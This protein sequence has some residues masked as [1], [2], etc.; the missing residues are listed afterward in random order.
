MSQDQSQNAMI[1]DPREYWASSTKAGYFYRDPV[2][3]AIGPDGTFVPPQT[4]PTPAGL[5]A[6][7]LGQGTSPASTNPSDIPVQSA[8]TS[9]DQYVP[10][11]YAGPVGPPPHLRAGWA[12]GGFQNQFR[13]NYHH[14]GYDRGPPSRGDASYAPTFDSRSQA[15]GA[16]GGYFRGQRSSRQY[17]PVPAQVRVGTAPVTPA[18]PFVATPPPDIT[19]AK[20]DGNGHPVFPFAHPHDAPIEDVVGVVPGA[21]ERANA[22]HRTETARIEEW[23]RRLTRGDELP[24]TPRAIDP[25]LVGV[26]MG[27]TIRTHAQAANLLRW[28]DS[29]CPQSWAM[30]QFVEQSYGL[31][32]LAYRPVGVGLI[33]SSQAGSRNR[34]MM[35]TTGAPPQSK[36]AARR[37]AAAARTVNNASPSTPG[38]SVI[39][40][41]LD[42]R[43]QVDEVI[44]DTD[45]SYVEPARVAV[46]QDVEMGAIS[47]CLGRS[48]AGDDTGA[49]NSR[50]SVEE[51]RDHWALLPTSG[52][53]K[54]MR[55]EKGVYPEAE[56][57]TPLAIDA[58]V[59]LTMLVFGPEDKLSLAEFTHQ[60]L[61]MFSCAGMFDEFCRVGGYHS[62]S[63]G[64]EHYNF[65]TTGL[66][67]S[68]L[69][70]WWC[71]HGIAPSSP[72]VFA[73]ESFARSHRNRVEGGS[74]PENDLFVNY[75]N[76]RTCVRTLS[77]SEIVV[78][79][80]LVHGPLCPSLH[81]GYPR[82]PKEL[83]QEDDLM[84]GNT[85]KEEKLDWSAE[86]QVPVFKF[87]AATT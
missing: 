9:R 85:P 50:T 27:T 82:H 28:S 40:A 15:R 3:G 14:G 55:T 42:A 20:R 37:A 23:G 39:V 24:R 63:R 1:P 41:T 84:G 48:P 47:A 46:E 33:L 64:P 6:A 66:D 11:G 29:G 16:R 58:C 32:P 22:W 21:D 12:R 17:N 38:P 35:A 10:R 54:A 34:Y 53:P 71:T 67:W 79:E 78:W 49:L 52:W 73:F 7:Y 77:S 80:R 75:P 70:S 2:I 69:A 8:P 60:T 44:V 68:L 72:S 36:K 25:A 65:I 4:A 5:L 19:V 86:E 83:G 13:G 26:W 45:T 18:T 43:A 81:S 62:L 56:Y 31:R 59:A 30:V 61:W 57:D 76:D 74:N 87:G 51:A